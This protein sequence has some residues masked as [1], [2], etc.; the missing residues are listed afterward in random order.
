VILESEMELDVIKTKFTFLF[1]V[2]EQRR[3]NA[4]LT[5]MRN[6]DRGD[7]ITTKAQ[8][9][10]IQPEE[11]TTWY[12]YL[13][14]EWIRRGLRGDGGKVNSTDVRD[15]Y[16]EAIAWLDEGIAFQFRLDVSPRDKIFNHLPAS[17]LDLDRKN[18][19]ILV[20]QL[21]IKI[22]ESLKGFDMLI[23][24]TYQ[25]DKKKGAQNAFSEARDEIKLQLARCRR[26]VASWSS[27]SAASS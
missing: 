19:R 11:P 9:G 17:Q 20:V 5:T 27:S 23:E 26:A 18:N 12:Q 6:L 24:K 8:A 22:E 3:I 15:L 25:H 10:C 7:K 13:A 21:L 14:P 16:L 4:S 1:K 2:E